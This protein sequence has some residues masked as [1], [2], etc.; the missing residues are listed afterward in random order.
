MLL[1]ISAVDGRVKW[2]FTASATETLG[3]SAPG[4][5]SVMSSSGGTWEDE[6]DP[7]IGRVRWQVASAYDAITTPDGIVTAPGADSTDQIS[8][9]DTLTGQTRWHARLLRRPPAPRNPSPS[10][11]NAQICLYYLLP[12]TLPSD[13]DIR[14]YGAFPGGL[15]CAQRLAQLSLRYRVKCTFAAGR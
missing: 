5:I 10:R 15:T 1:G 13:A 4:L 2:Q 14:R 8:L 6:L 11:H 3:V 12:S 9:R 7:A